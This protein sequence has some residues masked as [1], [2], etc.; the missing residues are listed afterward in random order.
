M[1]QNVVW[2]TDS[3]RTRWR[4]LSALLDSQPWPEE[5]VGIK[6]GRGKG[7]GKKDGREERGVRVSRVASLEGSGGGTAPGDT[8][9]GGETRRKKIVSKFTKNSGETRSDR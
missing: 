7:E 6:E 9:Q 5:E 1:R 4:S 2:R 8:L 3:A